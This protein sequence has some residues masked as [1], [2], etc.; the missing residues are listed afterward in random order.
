MLFG[1]PFFSWSA[2]GN[3]YCTTATTTTTT[4]T[5]TTPAAATTTTTITT[6]RHYD[7]DHDHCCDHHHHNHRL[8]PSCGL[9]RVLFCSTVAAACLVLQAMKLAEEAMK[10]GPRALGARRT[11]RDM[12][13]PYIRI[14]WRPNAEE[15]FKTSRSQNA[16][17]E[18]RNMKGEPFATEH[19]RTLVI[20]AKPGTIFRLEMS[21]ANLR[22]HGREKP[23][24]GEKAIDMHR[25][26]KKAE[27]WRSR[28]S[29][30][31]KCLKQ[32]VRSPHC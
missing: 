27:S 5:A 9:L 16:P 28:E 1:T 26:L 12:S 25:H 18:T 19:Y 13:R 29:R 21:F 15:G 6:W 31:H 2:F 23:E 4:A 3:F 14:A 11:Q 10:P 22:E 20:E 32:S 7:N 24:K 30:H 17:H 8:R